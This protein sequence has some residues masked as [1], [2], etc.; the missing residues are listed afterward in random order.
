MSSVT[1]TC[2]PSGIMGGRCSISAERRSGE[3]REFLSGGVCCCSCWEEEEVGQFDSCVD[4]IVCIT[5]IVVI[6][7]FGWS[8]G[9]LESRH[10]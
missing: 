1:S 8:I 6:V 3:V 9:H 10:G 5:D 7:L 2:E 4:L